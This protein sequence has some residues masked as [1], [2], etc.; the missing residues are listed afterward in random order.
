MK[1]HNHKAFHTIATTH[2]HPAFSGTNYASKIS[3]KQPNAIVMRGGSIASA[4]SGDAESG[5]TSLRKIMNTFASIWGA[6]GVVMILGKS[7]KRI[8][9]IA[10][11]PFNG[12]SNP[13][14][15]FQLG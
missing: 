3:V 8:V 12:V 7:I 14:S 6:F 1:P 11:E 13:L 5:D 15:T 9:P 2:K 4:A 10:L